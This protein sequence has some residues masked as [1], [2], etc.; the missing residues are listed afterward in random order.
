VSRPPIVTHVGTCP[1]TGKR[2]FLTK[3]DAR[4][5]RRRMGEPGLSVFRCEDCELWHLGHHGDLTRDQ[6]RARRSA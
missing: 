2:R 1:T 4:I 5:I 6:H 3:H